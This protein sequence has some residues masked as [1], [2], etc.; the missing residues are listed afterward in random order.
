MFQRTKICTGLLIAIGSGS[1]GFAG[2]ALAQDTGAVQRVEV[3]GSSIKRIDA[4]TDAPI[5]TMTHEEIARTGAT[6]VEEL[7]RHISAANSSNSVAAA[8]SSGATTGGISTISLR[9]LGAA[10]TLILVNGQRSAPYGDPSDSVA[11]DVDS[12][13]VAAIERV[14][15]LKEGAGAIYG[16]DAVAG[17]V[18]FVLRKNYAG[19]E[20]N[21]YYGTSY[22]GKG[23][24]RKASFVQ[25]FNGEKGNA[26]FIMTFEHDG[27]LYGRDRSFASTN[28]HPEHDNFSASS[29]SVPANIAI[30]GVAGRFNPAVPV[31]WDPTA[32][33]G[34]GAFVANGATSCGPQSTFSA[35][36]AAT[37]C[38][39]D[40]A[41]Y[42]SLTPDVKRVGGMFT[43]TYDLSDAVR[44]HLDLSLTNKKAFTSIQPSP[45]GSYVGIPFT[46]TTASPYY[47]TAYVADV[48]AQATAA[49]KF[50]GTTNTPALD[51]RYRPFITGTRDLVDSGTAARASFGADGNVAGWDYSA[52]LLYSTS[53]AQESLRS[54]YFSISGVEKLLNG[55]DKDA[56]GNTLWVNPFGANSD[57]VSAAARATNFIGTAFKTTTSLMDAQLKL[58]KDDL[59]KLS[60]GNVGAAVGVEFRKDSFKLQSDPA[61]GAG[62]ISGYGGNFS[63]FD[64]SRNVMS[65]FGELDVPV[66]KGF[67]IDGAVRYDRYGSTTNPNSL[68]AGVTTL[69]TI[70]IAD[71]NGDPVG[72]PAGVVNAVATDGTQNA[73]SFGQATGKL[74]AKWEVTKQL[75]LRSTFSTGF[76][77][78]SLL[79][80]YAPLQTGV[81]AIVN[82][83]KRCSDPAD[84][85][86]DCATQF[87]QYTGGRGNLKP[88]RSATWTLGGVFEPVKGTSVALDYYHTKL[89]DEITT[90]GIDYLLS[91]ESAYANRI[92][93]A[94]ADGIGTAGPIIG[95]DQRQENVS[96]AIV[97]GFDFDVSTSMTTSAGRFGVA[98]GGT[99]QTKWDTV[100]PDGSKESSIGKT[101]STTAGF[102]PRMKL[103]TELSYALPSNV[104]SG[105]LIY[106][107]QSHATDIC[108]SL[109][110]D[111]LGN[112]AAGI[113]PPR[114]KAYGTL[115]LQGVW[116]PTKMFTITAGVKN[117]GNTKP[118]Y[119][120]GAGGAFQASYDPTYVDPHGRFWYGS[121]T[122]RF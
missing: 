64:R 8:S 47:P 119:V 91:H 107:W 48:I 84:G 89:R 90:L 45:I 98:V 1:F 82:D 61:L 118:P 46:L 83:P 101:S 28:I 122:M 105:S 34:K 59:V 10:R 14:E 4:E 41:P 43:G 29:G 117:V 11:V 102:V 112:C 25:G 86:N 16:S 110:Q 40:T 111:D 26:T 23:S 6:T 18:N 93:R 80:L 87:N 66:F 79:D 51:L 36:F 7:L 2:S 42:V 38:L 73:S 27:A 63:A 44:L 120:N 97:S 22:D 68:A 99:W 106:N 50:T 76:R 39:F 71:T 3:I 32:K 92:T 103:S 77:A 114:V 5:T 57:A 70:S 96:Q 113:S 19:T 74:G 9:G 31:K 69:N 20:L 104:L 95:V 58:S 37:S 72:L 35:T 33:G 56:Q 94:P 109:D 12:I 21:A 116:N 78:P 100:N 54:G 85:G 55:Q 15:V 75:L 53:Q 60:A 65:V 62:D 115:D 81:T 24:I 67:N 17:V 52:N 13:P 88:E 108:G 30:P 121:A 49:G